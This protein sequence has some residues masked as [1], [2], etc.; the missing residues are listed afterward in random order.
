MMESTREVN[1]NGDINIIKR[2]NK[3]MVKM[4]HAKAS[5]LTSPMKI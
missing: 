1:M 4:I 5:K 2:S 3:A